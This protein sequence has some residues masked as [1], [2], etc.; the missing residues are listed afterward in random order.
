MAKV[1]DP[2]NMDAVKFEEE[3]FG[4]N[5]LIHL[6]EAKWMML[7]FTEGD[8][9]PKRRMAVVFPNGNLFLIPTSDLTLDTPSKWLVSSVR[10]KLEQARKMREGEED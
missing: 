5:E 1:V 10:H 3:G 7:T 4:R 2:K 8:A 9:K 6:E